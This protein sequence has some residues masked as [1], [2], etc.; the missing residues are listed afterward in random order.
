MMKDFIHPVESVR[1]MP[2][3][4]KEG[5]P[6]DTDEYR[7]MRSAETGQLYRSKYNYAGKIWLFWKPIKD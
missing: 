3:M 1:T 5:C 4:I 6:I 2:T 7:Y